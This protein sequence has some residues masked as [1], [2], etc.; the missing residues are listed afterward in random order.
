MTFLSKHPTHQPS[1][2]ELTNLF[3]DKLKAYF[4]NVDVSVVNCPDLTKAPFNLVGKGLC[5]KNATN[6]VIDVG[7]EGFMMPLARLDKSAYDIVQIAKQSGF[8]DRAHIVG[9]A[10]GPFKSIGYNSELILNVAFENDQV[11]NGTKCSYL[12]ER[13]SDQDS[14]YVVAESPNTF[15]NI[16]GN[17]Y[18]SEGLDGNVLKVKASKRKNQDESQIHLNGN[19]N[20]FKS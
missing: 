15:F 7:G 11:L 6:K 2:E 12:P 17:F 13:K 3:N 19:L 9:A 4:E 5:S 1:L 8:T 16:L 10:C 18:A 14:E 20:Q